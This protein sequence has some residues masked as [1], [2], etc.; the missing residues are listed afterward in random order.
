MAKTSFPR[1]VARTSFGDA[2]D[3]AVRLEVD[4]QLGHR[5]LGDARALG[6][7]ADGR[8]GIVEELEHVGVGEPD[9]GVPGPC[10]PLHQLVRHRA[11]GLAQ[12][13]REVLG[14]VGDERIAAPAGAVVAIAG[15]REHTIRNESDAEAVAYVVFAPGAAMES[16]VREAAVAAPADVPA[17]AA[18]HGVEMT[19][20]VLA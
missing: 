1:P 14:R 9:L 4:D 5:P 16:F 10:E 7:S 20:L 12:E 13:D 17:L 15:G 19:R 18:R 8:A 2:L 6:E 3:V 11:E